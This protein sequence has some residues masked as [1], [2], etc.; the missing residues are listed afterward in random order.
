MISIC[1]PTYNRAEYLAEALDSC[2][3]QTYKD[4]EIVVVDDGSTDSTGVLLKWYKLKDERISVVR[5]ENQGIAK[6]RNLAV[7]L[8]SGEYIA[9]MD[10]DDICGPDRL[11][12]Q[13]EELEKGF[14]VCYSSYLRADENATVIDGVT[15]PK[16]SEI[17]LE[18]LQKD[19]GIPHVTILARRECF[20]DHPY[21]D[22]YRVNDDYQLC[23]DW[24]R[25][26]YRL[27]RIEDPLVIVRFHEQ[28]TSRIAWE[29]IREINE[30][31][32]K[33]LSE[34]V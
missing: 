33:E 22:E 24:V 26:G 1:L 6:A 21:R 32:R 18:S 2:L 16:P 5:T 7:S 27:A 19:Q 34:P 17:T 11:D 10:S 15:A 23:V 28:N 25:A 3:A 12:R 4:I 9:V 13:L 14:D 29:E 30:K 8:S 31:V 20:T